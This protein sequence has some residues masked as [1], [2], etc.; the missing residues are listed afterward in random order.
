MSESA[1]WPP[2]LPLGTKELPSAQQRLS[3]RSGERMQEADDLAGTADSGTALEW[4]ILPCS[5]RCGSRTTPHRNCL[6]PSSRHHPASSDGKSALV[7]SF[8]VNQNAR[9]IL[10][11]LSPEERLGG[12]WFLIT[13][14]REKPVETAHG[15]GYIA[16]HSQYFTSSSQETV[17]PQIPL[18]YSEQ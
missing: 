15:K 16:R 13:S 5:S 1:Q 2:S 18:T 11:S 14:M 3:W 10:W 12:N 4:A 8:V 17:L 9:N 7:R 6:C